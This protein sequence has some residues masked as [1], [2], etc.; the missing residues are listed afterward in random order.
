MTGPADGFRADP[1]RIAGHADEIARVAAVV[2]AGRPTADSLS[3]DAYGL[4]GGLFAGSATAAMGRGV[5]T[6]DDL[7]AA[8][9]ATAD[10]LRAS[11]RSYEDAEEAALTAL[12]SVEIPAAPSGMPSTVP[13]PR[14]PA[15]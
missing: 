8:L 7:A 15:P 12:S 3:D 2:R 5:A 10:R 4:V 1:A 9:E 11:A 6:V 14:R 13:D